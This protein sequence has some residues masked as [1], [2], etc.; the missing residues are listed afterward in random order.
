MSLI[1][2]QLVILYT[3]LRGEVEIFLGL[4]WAQAWLRERIDFI[5]P[6]AASGPN[7]SGNDDAQR[8]SMDFGQRFTVHFPGEY[9]LLVLADL[10]PWNRDG[11][12]E[13]IILSK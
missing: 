5:H 2:S 6:L 7:V 8:S 13:Y 9:Y 4:Y 11:I 12:V 3:H 1:F 10:A